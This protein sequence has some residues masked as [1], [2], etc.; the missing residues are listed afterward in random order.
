MKENAS[1]TAFSEET[2]GAK[3]PIFP[4]CLADCIFFW[5]RFYKNLL[6]IYFLLDNEFC[7]ML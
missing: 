6:K 1:K 2:G 4:C 5:S 3:T 7:Y